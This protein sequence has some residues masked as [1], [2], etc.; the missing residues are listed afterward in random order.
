MNWTEQHVDKLASAMWFAAE[1]IRS[2]EGIG[3]LA[4]IVGT[5]QEWERLRHDRPTYVAR[6]QEYARI[7][8]AVLGDADD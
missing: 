8:L 6:W 7:A 3:P 5:G 1:D 2:G 4:P